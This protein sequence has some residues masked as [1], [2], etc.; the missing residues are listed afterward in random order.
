MPARKV[1]EPNNP[2][3][4]KPRPRK[5]SSPKAQP[6]VEVP[7]PDDD[8][9]TEVTVTDVDTA[10]SAPASRPPQKSI[11]KKRKKKG[12]RA[13]SSYVLFAIEHRKGVL[14]AQPGLKLGEISKLCGAAWKALDEEGKAPWIAKAKEAKEKKQTE[15]S[16]QQGTAAPG[17]KRTASSYLLFAMAKRRDI[18]KE[19]P[20]LSIGMVSKKCG[21]LWK[22]LD[23]EEKKTWQDKANELKKQA[24]S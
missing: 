16:E 2:D 15:L 3:K 9:M 23:A 7:V 1:T 13:P 22:E 19:E 20:T 6:P 10:V 4:A 21:M 24:A 8:V 17:K 14:E 12:T 18:L 5:A 11:V